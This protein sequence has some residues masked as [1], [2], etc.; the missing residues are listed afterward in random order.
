MISSQLSGS[1]LSRSVS[2]T[3]HSLMLRY[4]NTAGKKLSISL[5]NTISFSNRLKWSS[6][7]CKILSSLP[8]AGRA[9]SGIFY[10]Y[11]EMSRFVKKRWRAHLVTFRMW[12]T[13][14]LFSSSKLDAFHSLVD[15]QKY[16]SYDCMDKSWQTWSAKQIQTT[17]PRKES[18]RSSRRG[19]SGPGSTESPRQW[20]PAE[21]WVENIYHQSQNI[22]LVT[23]ENSL[24]NFDI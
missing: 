19:P 23:R 10:S 1:Y 16:I 18:Q 12:V 14:L 4:L 6:L 20:R 21:L 17:F 11:S 8:A 22:L 15:Y 3:S 24:V 9:F 2:S 5:K 13:P 7:N